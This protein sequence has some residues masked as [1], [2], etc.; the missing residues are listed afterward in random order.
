MT[1]EPNPTDVQPL[2]SRTPRRG[3]RDTSME[4][5]LAEVREA[6]W[7]ALALVATLEEEKEWLGCPLTRSQSEAQAQS[8]SRDCHRWRSWGWKRRCH[9]VQPEH[10]SAPYFEYHPSQRG[11]VSEGNEEAPKDFN[12]EDRW[13]WGPEVEC[14]LWGPVKS[15]EE[16]NMKMPPPKPPI[17]ELEN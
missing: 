11:S 2:R 9:Q 17:E 12:L 5:S 14:F 3:R 6:S 15:S 8:R 7:K 10:C 1:G 16:E 13:G 4:R